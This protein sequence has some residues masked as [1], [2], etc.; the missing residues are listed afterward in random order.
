MASDASFRL[1]IRKGPQPNQVYELTKDV[2]TLGRDI[3]NDIVVNDPEVSR[4]HSRL[5]RI[6]SG[7]VVEDLGSTNGTLINHRQTTGQQGR[8]RQYYEEERDHAC[9][10]PGARPGNLLEADRRFDQRPAV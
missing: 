3:T 5:T 9:T 8:D 4:H 2:M 7:Y 1:I 10:P 6:A